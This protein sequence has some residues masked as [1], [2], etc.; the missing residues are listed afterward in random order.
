MTGHP[1]Q[2]D[3]ISDAKPYAHDA[4]FCTGVLMLDPANDGGQAGGL[5]EMG[6]E[7]WALALQLT[8]DE[9]DGVRRE[10][11]SALGAAVAAADG[12][13]GAEQVC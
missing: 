8:E 11:C 9:D 10:V 3:S 1:F 13:P 6:L 12:V 5:T 4:L 2:T 7:A